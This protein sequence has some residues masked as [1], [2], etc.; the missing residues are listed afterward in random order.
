VRLCNA[1][2]PY[3]TRAPNAKSRAATSCF[4]T[5]LL[6]LGG[7]QISECR[8]PPLLV[9]DTLQEFSDAGA[10]IVEI[11]V[12]VAVDLFLFQGFMKDSQAA[13]SYGFPLR[14][15]LMAAWCCFSRSV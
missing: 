15:M 14:L 4:T 11:A 10:G 8:V 3:S 12:F 13:L 7:R 2:V 5:V 9:V 6:E 1:P